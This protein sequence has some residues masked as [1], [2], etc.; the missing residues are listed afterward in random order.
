MFRNISNLSIY[1][2]ELKGNIELECE[3]SGVD[4]FAFEGYH[5]EEDR[6]LTEDEISM[7]NDNYAG[8]IQELA[9]N[10]GVWYK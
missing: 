9:Y 4:S 3:L 8:E 10:N 5:V 6:M 7:I 1:S 2:P